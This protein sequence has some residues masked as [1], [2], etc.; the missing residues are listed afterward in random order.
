M[1]GECCWDLWVKAK[2][3][4][5]HP[6]MHRTKSRPIQNVNITKVEKLWT[7]PLKKFLSIYAE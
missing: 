6:E 3:G 7:S 2:N 5:K 1:G 4:D